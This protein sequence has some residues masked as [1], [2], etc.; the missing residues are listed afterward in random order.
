MGFK[1]LLK[2]TV[3]NIYRETFGDWGRKTSLGMGQGWFS[4]ENPSVQEKHW[5]AESKEKCV[6]QMKLCVDLP[7]S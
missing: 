7:V 4:A 5:L 6:E 1:H 3:H 2:E